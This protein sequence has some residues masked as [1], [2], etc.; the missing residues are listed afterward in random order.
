MPTCHDP[1]VAGSHCN[2]GVTH[3]TL[4]H[5]NVGTLPVFFGIAVYVFEGIGT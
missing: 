3:H 2:I 5:V 1:V 4:T